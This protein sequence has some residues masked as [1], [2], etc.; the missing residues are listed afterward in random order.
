M[1]DVIFDTIIDSAKLLPFLFL[2]YLLMEFLEH[3]SGDAA[4][5][6]LKKSGKIGPM[7]GG[8]FGI[9]PQCGFSASATSLYCGRVITLGTLIAVYLS[10]S[11]E[12]LPILI[13]NIS[14]GV[15]PWFIV[16]L[17][18][19]KL[20]IGVIAGFI[21][22]IIVRLWGK[23]RNEEPRIEEICEKE[24][25]HCEGHF[26]L[27]ALKHT[28]KIFIFIFV[29][30]F[31]LN[32]AI[33]FIGEEN[34]AE[35]LLDKPVLGNVIATLLGLIPN[36]ASSVI[37]TELGIGGIISIGAMLSGLLAN[38]GIGLAILFKNNRPL[39]DSFKILLLLFLVGVAVGCLVD[40]TPISSLLKI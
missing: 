19:V 6:L 24:N 10:T 7:L 39:S 4:Q 5:G 33:Y 31:A 20:I 3:R 35:L 14:K 18:L 21:I 11:D 15:S 34:I 23:R 28:I 13:S 29:L 40:L 37:L 27:S 12:M 16:K 36:C 8:A 26:A 1:L 17:L 32:S 9:V 2:T 22:D 25:C 30:N 38:A